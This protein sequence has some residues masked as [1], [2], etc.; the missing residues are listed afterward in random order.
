[1]EGIETLRG[2]QSWRI[3][4]GVSR[5]PDMEGIET[6]NGLDSVWL[7]RVSRCPDMEGIET[8]GLRAM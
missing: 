5:C 2:R 1:M 7:P 6:R 4:E 3:V 8:S